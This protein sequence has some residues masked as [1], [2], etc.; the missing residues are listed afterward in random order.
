MSRRYHMI[1]SIPDGDGEIEC[2]ITFRHTPG[3]PDRWYL[4]NGDPGYPG[5]PDEI[6]FIDAERYRNGRPAP[7]HM[8]T[9]D[10]IRLQDLAADWL[11]TDE[12]RAEALEHVE[13]ADERAREFAD[14]IRGDR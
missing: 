3:E 9:S 10:R 7:Y 6:D 12:G 5:H 11:E 4:R 13:A 14:N 1:T 8:A 2:R